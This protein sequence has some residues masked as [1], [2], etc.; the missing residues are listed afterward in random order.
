MALLAQ[1][2][3]NSNNSILSNYDMQLQISDGQCSAGIVMKR[4]IDIITNR[5]YKS[6]VGIMGK[7]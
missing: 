6:F 4:F 1:Q 7:C 5:D 2:H 3:I